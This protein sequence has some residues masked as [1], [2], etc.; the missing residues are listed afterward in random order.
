MKVNVVEKW[1]FESREDL[2][3]ADLLYNNKF[4]SR[5]LYFLQQGNEKLAKGLLISIGIQTPKRAKED[6]LVKSLLG[7]LPKEP[8]SY[9][10]KILPSLLSDLEK[11]VPAIED[12]LKSLESVKSEPKISELHKTIRASEKG[13]HKLKKKPSGLIQT[14][15]ELDNEIKGLQTILA[16]IDQAM[17]GANRDLD[18]LDMKKL[19]ETAIYYARRIGFR[20]E[21][22]LLPSSQ[23][24]KNAI[25]GSLSRA[26]L[27]SLSA[28]ISYL[29]DPLESAT[30]YPDS[31]YRSFDENSPY[32]IRF[33]DLH[34]IVA[35]CLEKASEQRYLE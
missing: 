19:G 3:C 33:K 16:N 13:V 15:D 34:D 30:R 10:H 25:L 29:I 24:V 12:L 1:M 7:F 23:Q 32:V 6:L 31:H 4:F 26:M 28:S 5:A 35:R 21:P 8:K 14:V 27:L 22:Q 9:G 2:A 18:K 20:A 17:N 11:S